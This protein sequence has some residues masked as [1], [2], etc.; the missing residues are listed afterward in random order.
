MGTSTLH[1]FTPTCIALLPTLTTSNRVTGSPP[2]P[3]CWATPFALPR[4]LTIPMALSVGDFRGFLLDAFGDKTLFTIKLIHKNIKAWDLFSLQLTHSQTELFWSSLT[5][6]LTHSM[7][8]I[9]VE[10]TKIKVI[11]LTNLDWLEGSSWTG[12]TPKENQL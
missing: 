8:L 9:S 3:L 11:V 12:L 7:W 4:P 1:K 6:C 2:F 5:R 10:L